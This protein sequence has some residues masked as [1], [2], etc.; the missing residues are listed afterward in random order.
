MIAAVSTISQDGQP[1]LCVIR[2]VARAML[3]VKATGYC[4]TE[5]NAADGVYQ[6]PDWAFDG[7]ASYL[8][9]KICPACIKAVAAM[10]NPT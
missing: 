4:G 3:T 5:G 6:V 10:K 2:N 1:K 8:G 9:A 7:R